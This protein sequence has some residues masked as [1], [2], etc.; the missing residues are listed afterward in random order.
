MAVDYSVLFGGQS[1]GQALTQGIGQGFQLAQ[2]KQQFDA[3][4]LAQEQAAKQLK[5]RQDLQDAIVNAPADAGADYW[6]GLVDKYQPLQAIGDRYKTAKAEEKQAV[7]NE[8]LN[9]KAAI[10]SGDIEAAKSIL[11]RRLLAA[12]N[13]GDQQAIDANRILLRQV[14]SNPEAAIP[15]AN[16]LMAGLDP[17]KF[18]ETYTKLQAPTTTQQ[19]RERDELARAAGYKPG[20]PEYKEYMATG[21]KTQDY[22]ERHERA[23]A[24][25]YEPGTPGYTQI[26]V[27]GGS[28]LVSVGATP[29]AGQKKLAES[30]SKLYDQGQK[31]FRSSLKIDRLDQLLSEGLET[32]FEAKIKG[33]LGSLG[34]KTEGLDKIQAFEAAVKDL[35]PEQREPGSGATSDFDARTFIQALPQLINQPGGN[36]LIIQGIKAVNEYDSRVGEIAEQQLSGQISSA[37][38]RQA[39]NQL[40]SDAV[41]KFRADLA[42]FN[43]TGFAMP[44]NEMS[45]EQLQ[46]VDARTLTDAQLD[47]YAKALEAL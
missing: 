45:Q 1:P 42:R 28:P 13:S 18:A 9:I 22:R 43:E 40:N 46:G 4:K 3:N 10:Q 19:Y 39:I 16:L 41:D 21:G 12:E 5:D 24:A 20:T 34:I 44:F 30:Y 36:K 2:M 31:A 37:Q 35:V 15:T 23:I 33:Y 14:E 29:T 47:E 8:A 25:G 6:Q 32:G 7:F 26:M 27:E 38:A 11:Q 17:E